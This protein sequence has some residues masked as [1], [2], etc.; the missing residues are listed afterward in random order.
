MYSP[1]SMHEAATTRP[2]LC[3]LST[4]PWLDSREYTFPYLR[5][6]FFFYSFAVFE[7]E[8]ANRRMR[9]DPDGIVRKRGYIHSKIHRD[10]VIR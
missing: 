10:S 9:L 4:E 5:T 1:L 2:H 6:D 3:P 8:K 7:R